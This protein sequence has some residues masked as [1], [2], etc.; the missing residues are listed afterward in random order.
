MGLDFDRNSTETLVELFEKYQLWEMGISNKGAFVEAFRTI[1]F[2]LWDDYNRGIITKR[3]IRKTRF[4]AVFAQFGLEDIGISY[5]VSADYL[6]LCP[7]KPYLIENCRE[8]LEYLTLHYRL[9]IITNGFQDVQSLKL[10]SAGIDH[11]FDCVVTSES[12]GQKK[13]KREIFDYALRQS[14]A[15]LADSLMIGD[16]LLTDI[17]GA[18]DYKM[19]CVYLNP[20]SLPHNEPITYEIRQLHELQHFL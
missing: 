6:E 2:Q 13:P 4:P 10:K 20:F 19:D 17:K 8:I 7:R 11:F 1:N 18:I 16:N 9:H 5:K 3:E 12:T 14:N 15:M